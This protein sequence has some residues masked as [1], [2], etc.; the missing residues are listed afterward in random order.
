MKYRNSE[1]WKSRNPRESNRNEN[2]PKLI[3]KVVPCA[4]RT[5]TP[6]IILLRVYPLGESHSAMATYADNPWRDYS[7]IRPSGVTGPETPSARNR[8]PSGSG[9]GAGGRASRTPA[10][11]DG[12]SLCATS[13]RAT[14]RPHVSCSAPHGIRVRVRVIISRSFWNGIL[15][16]FRNRAGK[17]FDFQKIAIVLIVCSF[18]LTY[19]I[20]EIWYPWNLHCLPLISEMGGRECPLSEIALRWKLICVF[21]K[22]WPVSDEVFAMLLWNSSA[23]SLVQFLWR[24]FC[25]GKKNCCFKWI[26]S[27]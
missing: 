22:L 9:G 2:I 11:R 4:H 18:V 25:P 10:A 16:F 19:E 12:F 1:F 3:K 24:F 14:A 8:S 23:L 20:F 7:V 5:F 21:S 17:T 27:I 13:E 26:F 6:A 15:T